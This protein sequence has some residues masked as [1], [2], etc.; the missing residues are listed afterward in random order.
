MSL[1]KPARD[2]VILSSCGRFGTHC[3]GETL[4]G[5]AA[6]FVTSLFFPIRS[7]GHCL[8]R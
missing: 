2:N 1:D 7:M 3:D 5:K 4:L 6:M 8:L